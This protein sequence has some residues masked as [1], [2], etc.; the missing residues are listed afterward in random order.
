MKKNDNVEGRFHSDITNGLGCQS[1]M[2]FIM[3]HNGIRIMMIGGFLG[4]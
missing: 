4:K 1:D 2:Q 3:K